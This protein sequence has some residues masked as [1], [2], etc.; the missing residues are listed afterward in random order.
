MIDFLNSLEKDYAGCPQAEELEIVNQPL[1]VM[2]KDYL[3]PIMA[4]RKDHVHGGG[5]DD[6]HLKRIDI[7][8]LLAGHMSPN[9]TDKQ[10]FSK[11]AFG[12]LYKSGYKKERKRWTK[13]VHDWNSA[14]GK[15][16]DRYFEI[17]DGIVFDQAGELVY[18][19]AAETFSR[20][21]P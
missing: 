20:K 6:E 4:A 19:K 7:L 14:I 2:L 11:E 17:L 8:E 9:K 12:L 5:F 10:R 15:L 13:L 1:C 16:L 21:M 18:P 3:K